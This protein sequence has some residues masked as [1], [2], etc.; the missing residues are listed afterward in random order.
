M[1]S[2]NLTFSTSHQLIV[3][4]LLAIGLNVNTLFNDY[5]LDDCV[6]LTQNSLVKQGLKGI[7]KLLTTDYVYGYSSQS[8]ILSGARYRP[9]SLLLFAVGY[10]IFGA[11]T[12]ISYLISV[13]LFALLILLLYKLLTEH[14]FKEQQSYLAFI[15]CMLFAV[16]PIH[17][18]VI[19]NV[20]SRDEIITF[21]FIII[22]MMAI[23][24]YVG[25]RQ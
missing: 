3:L 5:E 15:T 25:N 1:M 17:T 21:I 18:E 2:T 23:I 6:V 10:Q 24:K 4:M 22:S 9:L 8:N 7:P 20:K 16:H 19:A 12:F 11:K 14:I 13:L